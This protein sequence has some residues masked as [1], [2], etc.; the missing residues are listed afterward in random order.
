MNNNKTSVVAVIPARYGSTRFPGKPLALIK[1]KPLIQWVYERTRLSRLVDGVIVATDDERIEKAVREFGGDVVMTSKDHPTGTDR[2]AEAARNIVCDIV[3][4][5]Q[6]DE[7]LIHPEMIDSAVSPL[8][9]DPTIQMGTLC[10]KIEDPKEAFDPNV[11]KVVFDENGFALYFS[12]APIPWDR[13]AWKGKRALTELWLTGTMYKHIGL[14]VYQRR[15]LIEYAGMN[16][17]ALEHIEKLEQL[18]ALEKGFKIKVVETL[19]ESFGVDI[20]DD[21]GK[22]EKFIEAG[23]AEI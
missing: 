22:I 6:G 11:V 2:I 1:G 4:N 21:L 12:R 16:Q 14:Y 7:P 10:R 15:F 18:R 19:H 9:S 8:I 20:P 13:D 5:V 23:R 17:T 3:V